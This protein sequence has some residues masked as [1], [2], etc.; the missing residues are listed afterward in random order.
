MSML[1]GMFWEVEHAALYKPGERLRDMEVS[2]KMQDRN[3]DVIRAMFAFET[4]FE[5]LVATPSAATRP[6]SE[7]QATA[8][9]NTLCG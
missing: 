8:D 1:I 3:A 6:H 9:F 4:E 5:A 7:P 2:L